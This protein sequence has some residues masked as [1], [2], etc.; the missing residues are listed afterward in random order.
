MSP[1]ERF[2]RFACAAYAAAACNIEARRYGR[3]LFLLRGFRTWWLSAASTL[4]IRISVKRTQRLH[5]WYAFRTA[6][7]RYK[8]WGKLSVRQ[9]ELRLVAL[10]ALRASLTAPGMRGAFVQW[11]ELANERMMA[12][13]RLKITMVEFLMRIGPRRAYV[14]WHSAVQLAHSMRSVIARWIQR[15]LA[16][17]LQTWRSTHTQQLEKG[18]LLRRAISCL[19]VEG[20][21]KRSSLNTWAEHVRTEHA[22][23]RAA[24]ALIKA[25]TGTGQRRAWLAWCTF[26]QEHGASLALVERMLRALCGQSLHRGLL[27]WCAYSEE[28]AN[29]SKALRHAVTGWHH[30]G[31]RTVWNTWQLNAQR[32][33][34]AAS[35]MERV[36][37][38]TSLLGTAW[39]LWAA[40]AGSLAVAHRQIGAALATLRLIVGDG[41]HYVAAFRSWAFFAKG[42]VSQLRQLSKA[43]KT[44]V[45]LVRSGGLRAGMSAW[46]ARVGEINAALSA[47]RR[48]A[49]AIL[50]AQL[51][52]ATNTWLL[53]S[54]RLKQSELRYSVAF[55]AWSSHGPTRAWVHWKEIALGRA[56]QQRGMALAIRR[57]TNVTAA[58]AF[59]AWVERVL[60]VMEAQQRILSTLKALGLAG[61]VA[62]QRFLAFQTWAHQASQTI[63]QQKIV[64]ALVDGLRGARRRA[65]FVTWSACAVAI[66][67][68]MCALKNVVTAL[69]RQHFRRAIN[70]WCQYAA[71]VAEATMMLRRRLDVWRGSGPRR[72]WEAWAEVALSHRRL[73]S[74]LHSILGR[75]RAAAFRAWRQAAHANEESEDAQ[76]RIR[77]ALR[78][79]NMIDHGVGR[80]IFRAFGQWV[81][82]GQTVGQL[83]RA[84]LALRSRDK[85]C[86]MTTW[87]SNVNSHMT[88]LDAAR[89]VVQSLRGQHRR[90]AFNAW[91]ECAESNRVAH[92]QIKHSFAM[93]T[94]Q[95]LGRAWSTWRAGTDEH[96]QVVSALVS[97]VA[98]LRHGARSRAWSAWRDA[99]L[100]AADA[101]RRIAAA[102]SSLGLGPG[103]QQQRQKHAAFATWASN[104]LPYAEQRRSAQKAALA[105]IDALMG[106]GLRRALSTWQEF[107]A[108]RSSTLAAMSK[109]AHIL[110]RQH[111]LRAFATWNEYSIE[112][113]AAR[114]LFARTLGTWTGS[115]LRYAWAAWSRQAMDGAELT[116]HLKRTIS[117]LR[118]AAVSRAFSSWHDVAVPLAESHRR[119]RRAIRVLHADGR[120]RAMFNAL[121]TWREVA[122][123]IAQQCKKLA[124]ALR[125]MGL[126]GGGGRKMLLA[127]NSWTWSW[128]SFRL[129]RW[130]LRA[131]RSSARRKGFAAWHEVT[132]S[133]KGALNAARRVVQSLRGQHR[134]RAFNAWVEC[135]ESNRVAHAQIKHSFAMLTSQ[136]L[137]RAWSTWRAG[138]DEHRQVV[139]ALVSVVARLRHG[140][141]SRAW[142]AWRDAALGAAD[143]TRR[144]AAALSS[145]G[146]GPGGQ[147]QRQKHAAF[148][149]WASNTL[150]YAEQRRSAQKAAL[151]LIDALMGRGLRRA[152]STWQ[153]FS[154]S[155]SSTL[156]AMSKVAHILRRQHELRAFATWLDA[157]S[158][159]L[160]AQR[161]MKTALAAFAGDVRIF[162]LRTWAE[163]VSQRSHMEACV[164]RLAQIG[165]ARAFVSWADAADEQLEFHRRIRNALSALGVSDRASKL[166]RAVASWCSMVHARHDARDAIASARISLRL[167]CGMQRLRMW[168]RHRRAT[169][170]W[171]YT[172]APSVQRRTAGLFHAWA[173]RS[174]QRK[175]SR[176]NANQLKRLMMSM[177][178]SWRRL[179]LSRAWRSWCAQ[180]AWPMKRQKLLNAARRVLHGALHVTFGWWQ[181]SAARARAVHELS[182]RAAWTLAHGDLYC[183]FEVW[184]GGWEHVCSR[185]SM[186]QAAGRLLKG[187]MHLF[188]SWW[189]SSHAAQRQYVRWA[190]KLRRKHVQT[191]LWRWRDRL[192]VD[193]ALRAAYAAGVAR[194]DRSRATQLQSIQAALRTSAE[195]SMQMLSRYAEFKKE[196][197]SERAEVDRNSVRLTSETALLSARLVE[198][199]RDKAEVLQALEASEAEK[200]AMRLEQQALTKEII[201][202]NARL[203][204][205]QRALLEECTRNQ[206]HEHN[207]LAHE[208]QGGSMSADEGGIVG[209]I[210]EYMA[211][212][213]Y[214]GA[215]DVEP[216]PSTVPRF[217]RLMPE[218]LDRPGPRRW[219]P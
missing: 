58:R 66:V 47:I 134:R 88:A 14:T 192:D 138:T 29:A 94:S 178:S 204:D 5:A 48:V 28:C 81:Q 181:Q 34:E 127:F 172:I 31:L 216:T 69:R 43:A 182:K 107:S 44:L 171:Q 164:V 118:N 67:A 30:R 150:P 143:A 198:R 106:R 155:R 114:R 101:T 92:A 197:D 109:V 39:R 147:Q 153:E 116:R 2:P 183:A 70:S 180:L 160:E 10:D 145:L 79:L 83:R 56:S 12:L 157:A 199:D 16:T 105:L 111:E 219:L 50:H 61:G 132:T 139:S 115:G 168:Q 55:G 141:R 75:Q 202:L 113:S 49:T 71:E 119:I 33:Q 120:G 77:R 86:A 104:T 217:L 214:G 62:R 201:E 169:R 151:A 46:M 194:T 167:F 102:L 123:P 176:A 184:V 45:A 122:L 4:D 54:V 149:T 15:G 163:A 97:V 142:S 60:R 25:I 9:K 218:P 3:A 158:A 59:D 166:H 32:R 53:C 42:R 89:R 129:A 1:S 209:T 196:Y 26:S 195:K 65:A 121:S 110:R 125:A 23:R 41:R 37:A 152:L 87:C 74:A 140:A 8:S 7:E 208:R 24:T 146:L 6:F 128:R 191:F 210:D 108:S 117:R 190:A 68:S 96:R 52:R 144:I 156:A 84:V 40:K 215:V 20:R 161:V 124:S 187:D 57:L 27:T 64:I 165:I 36:R 173:R 100:G 95:G 213:E 200:H 78:A 189:Q 131:L 186:M 18:Q 13:E 19:G 137:G 11:F 130:G 177:V 93:L 103:G 82:I 203:I 212:D 72:A 136:G 126:G 175:A 170:Q 159:H 133:R 21:H 73:R 38:S 188:F 162:A 205:A 76:R 22:L 211:M 193:E 112:Q 154:A 179:Q 80:L 63:A 207:D 17:A 85:R 35:L 98:R 148:A 185:R 135:A 206:R 99:A 90:R 174:S 51:R 91:V